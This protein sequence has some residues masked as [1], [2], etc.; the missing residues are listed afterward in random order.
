MGHGTVAAAGAASACSACCARSRLCRARSASPRRAWSFVFRTQRPGYAGSSSESRSRDCKAPRGSSR[1]AWAAA[2]ANR[3]SASLGSSLRRSRAIC[4]M[5]ESLRALSSWDSRT[6]PSAATPATAPPLGDSR[7]T[8][9]PVSVISRT[10]NVGSGVVS[11][12]W[13]TP[14]FR[15]I[16]SPLRVRS[17]SITPSKGWRSVVTSG[18]ECMSFSSSTRLVNP[19]RSNFLFALCAKA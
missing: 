12:R 3:A 8:C 10:R 1:V 2:I 7:T 19:C 16:R 15:R 6:L 13:R 11:L 18:P 5:R 14:I 17:I 9:I 4:M